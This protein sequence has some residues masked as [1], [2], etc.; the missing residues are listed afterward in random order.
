MNEKPAVTALILIYWRVQRRMAKHTLSD[1][2]GGNGLA[3]V[4]IDE[5][6]L[7]LF[8]KGR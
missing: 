5:P 1:L 8:E 4:L 7:A 2:N 6:L 3:P